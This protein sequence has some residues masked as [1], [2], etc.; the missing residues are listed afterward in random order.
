VST[1]Q[2]LYQIA[3]NMRE[4]VDFSNED[5]N[6]GLR[7]KDLLQRKMQLDQV[8]GKLNKSLSLQP[9]FNK[10]GNDD[11]PVVAET[12]KHYENSLPLFTEASRLLPDNAEAYY[13]IACIHAGR[14]RI[15]ESIQ[16]LD[17]AI[18][19]GFNRWD[20]IETDSDLE[21]IRRYDGYQLLVKGK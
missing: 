1:Q 9:G 19:K 12:K 13:H 17:Q 11:I 3:K 7:L 5:P 18:Q 4:A 20:I 10:L 8:I 2:K 15:P 21:N 6:L 14:G 16:Y